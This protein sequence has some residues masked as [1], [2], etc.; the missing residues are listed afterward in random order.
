MTLYVSAKAMDRTLNVSI[1]K[2][3]EKVG[4]YSD[5]IASICQ[6]YRTANGVDADL[7]TAIL[8]YIPAVPGMND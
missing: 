5:S 7:C 4:S 6:Q 3:D 2:G 8:R 1:T